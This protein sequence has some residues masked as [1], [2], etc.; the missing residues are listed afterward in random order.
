MS[1]IPTVVAASVNMESIKTS[2]FQ[3]LGYLQPFLNISTSFNIFFAGQGAS[4]ETFNVM[5]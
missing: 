1:P 3:H 5:F 4:M 2:F